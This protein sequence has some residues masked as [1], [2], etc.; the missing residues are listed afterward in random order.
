MKFC[1]YSSLPGHWRCPDIVSVFV[2]L[3]FIAA[4]YWSC[5]KRYKQKNTDTL[6]VI[7]AKP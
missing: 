4:A 2:G 3:L 7:E 6:S 1:K 5:S